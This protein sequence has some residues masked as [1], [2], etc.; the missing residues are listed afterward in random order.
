MGLDNLKIGENGDVHVSLVVLH[1]IGGGD[2]D[3]FLFNL[4]NPLSFYEGSCRRGTWCFLSGRHPPP[5]IILKLPGR[6][7]KAWVELLKI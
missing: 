7:Q 5:F 6:V 3:F 1:R 4:T 2:F